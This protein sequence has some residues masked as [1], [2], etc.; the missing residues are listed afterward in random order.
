MN[1]SNSTYYLWKWA[2]N[3]LSG[4]PNEVFSKLLHG[5]MHPALQAFDARPILRNLRVMATKRRALGEE[6]DWQIQPTTTPDRANFIFLQCPV[7]PKYGRFRERFI[8]LV[9]PQGLS[10]YAEEYGSIIE[11]L[12][13]K[14]NS[15][16]FGDNPE[17]ELFDIG[18]D[19]LP[20]LLGRLNSVEFDP[21]VVLTNRANH[22]VQ[23]H[24]DSDGFTVEW[25]ENR[26]LTDFTDYDQ[27]RAGSAQRRNTERGTRFVYESRVLNSK[28]VDVS[29]QAFQHERLRFGDILRIFQAFL[30]GESKPSRYRWRSIR[31][32]FEQAKHQHKAASH[33]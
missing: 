9:Y 22:F 14:L 15:F 24:P 25:R 7:I 33:E 10:G 28:V 19:D 3:D 23:C 4:Q 27:W 21:F 13:P 30:R 5:K 16:A 6:W 17:A 12:L 26:S 18:E 29:I 8:N 32:E 2:D 20:V 31:Q 1:Q 11:C